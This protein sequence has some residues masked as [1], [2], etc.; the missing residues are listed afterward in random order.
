MA[1]SKTRLTELGTAAGLLWNRPRLA[2]QRR[3]DRHPRHPAAVW[4]PV[5]LEATRP[6]SRDRALLLAALDNGRTFRQQVLQAASRP[7]RGRVAART[8]GCRTSP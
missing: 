2:R 7:G 3:A 4:Q 8:P 6:A 1:S 5:V